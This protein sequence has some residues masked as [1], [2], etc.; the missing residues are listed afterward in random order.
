MA[1]YKGQ[2]PINFTGGAF[3][4]GQTVSQ[5]YRGGNIVYGEISVTPFEFLLDI[6]SAFVAYSFT[7]KLNSAYTGS[8]FRVKR[9]SDN[10]EQDIG[11]VDN[12]IDTSALT[13]FV[14][15]GNGTMVTWYDQSGAGAHLTGSNALGGDLPYVVTSGSLVTL[16]GKL[17]VS[18]NGSTQYLERTT[19]FTSAKVNEIM[20]VATITSRAQTN[21]I[22]WCNP[23]NGYTFGTYE[24]GTNAVSI[25]K[26]DGARLGQQ[27]ITFNTQYL[28]DQFNN[29]D[30]GTDA[31]FLNLNGTQTN[32]TTATGTWLAT[33]MNKLNLGRGPFGASFYEA[34]K[35]N[36]WVQFADATSNR[37]ALK[38]NI[39]S[40]Y[41][42]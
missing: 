37:T 4:G 15:A 29:V 35:F 7:R 31:S 13:S 14:G 12:L 17:A 28:V 22:F 1:I 32:F 38:A 26:S 8:A 34:G 41:G 42:L 9:S 3:R 6:Q 39:N 16:G 5:I 24:T 23:D 36:E 20:A 33:S 19:A 2:F 21:S 11:F 40:F 10:T 18:T 27:T 30:G 25:V